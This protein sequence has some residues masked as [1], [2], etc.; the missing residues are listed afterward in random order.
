MQARILLLTK[1]RAISANH[2]VMKPAH[3]TFVLWHVVNSRQK[4]DALGVELLRYLVDVLT[5]VSI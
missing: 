1:L 3:L 4:G 5:V 2:T